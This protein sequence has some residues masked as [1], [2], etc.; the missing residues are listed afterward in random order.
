MRTRIVA[1]LAAGLVAASA[2]VLV[3]T[4]AF[5]GAAVTCSG[6]PGTLSGGTI[7][8]NVNVPSGSWCHIANETINGDIRVAP[9]GGLF[10]DGSTVNGNVSATNP[11]SFGGFICAGASGHFSVVVIGGTISGNVSVT[12]APADV[13]VGGSFGC[14]GTSIQKNLHVNNNSGL[15]Q[16][17]NN[18]VGGDAGVDNNKGPVPVVANNTVTGNLSCSPSTGAGNTAKHI[19]G[20]CT[21]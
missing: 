14:V 1:L 12:G 8:A 7:N 10:L 11:G 18:T 15:V 20:T 21:T 2:G 17:A 3:S 16:V 13:F 4:D 5:A 19:Y 6:N 9:G